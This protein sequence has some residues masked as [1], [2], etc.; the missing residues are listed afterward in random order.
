MTDAF[1]QLAQMT[2]VL[3]DVLVQRYYATG[4]NLLEKLASVE[5]ELPDAARKQIRLAASLRDQ[6]SCDADALADR[7]LDAATHAFCSALI[8]LD[9]AF[10]PG[11][12]LPSDLRAYGDRYLQ[13]V[14]RF[15]EPKRRAS[16][17]RSRPHAY[18]SSD[19]R[20]YARPK[21]NA[22]PQDGKKRAP[23]KPADAYGRARALAR[24]S[25]QARDHARA[26]L[27]IGIVVGLV[28]LLIVLCI[29]LA[30]VVLKGSANQDKQ[31]DA[32]AVR[33]G[34]QTPVFSFKA[35]N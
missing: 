3:E 14:K 9:G 34:E 2:Q 16:G 31:P 22:E 18:P 32:A 8:A 11:S 4:R 15:P 10:P 29:L 17:S 26:N 23:G 12:E 24:Q 30:T 5:N 27:F 7:N 25:L 13:P 28:A 21:P 1:A 6:A 33:V 19:T 35:E 20:S